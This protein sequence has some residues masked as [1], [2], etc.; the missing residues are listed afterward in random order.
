MR[1]IRTEAVSRSQPSAGNHLHTLRTQESPLVNIVPRSRYS[2]T[3]ELAQWR[4]LWNGWFGQVIII[5]QSGVGCPSALLSTLIFAHK[6][7]SPEAVEFRPTLIKLLWKSN[8][9]TDPN[10][11]I[12]PELNRNGTSIEHSDLLFSWLRFRGNLNRI[13]E[14]TALEVVYFGESTD[15]QNEIFCNS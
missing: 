11:S 1:P 14:V 8:P 13:R 10:T 6:K 5:D 15:A 4:V 7:S 2:W 9:T 12:T 3:G